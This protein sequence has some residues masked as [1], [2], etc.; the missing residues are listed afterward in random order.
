MS[1]EE[2]KEVSTQEQQTE[3]QTEEQ[4]EQ[5]ELNIS[6]L[7]SFRSVLEISSRRGTWLA[8]E[9]EDVGR[10]YK[11]LCAFLNRVLPKNEEQSTDSNET[12]ENNDVGVG[13]S[14]DGSSDDKIVI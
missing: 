14:T 2:N 11:R 4:S 13:S 3:Q 6:D 1:S 7:V 8:E 12:A 5:V 10:L 9:L